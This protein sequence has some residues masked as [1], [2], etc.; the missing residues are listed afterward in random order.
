M[1][2]LLREKIN[3]DGFELT[4]LINLGERECTRL[5]G[6]RA[7]AEINDELGGQGLPRVGEITLNFW[8]SSQVC[9]DCSHSEFTN[10]WELPAATYACRENIDLGPCASSCPLFEEKGEE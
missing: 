5:Y 10:F 2:D 7:L 3:K 9:M 1:N 8:P 6:K 4:D